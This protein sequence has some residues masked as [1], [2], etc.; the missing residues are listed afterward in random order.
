MQLH[1]RKFTKAEKTVDHLT[2]VVRNLP[3]I[4]FAIDPDG[5]FTLSEGAELNLLGREPEQVVGQS[6]FDV[7]R[8]KPEIIDNIRLALKGEPREYTH[9]MD[10]LVFN[11]RYQPIFDEDNLVKSVV[12]VIRN[13]TELHMAERA[14]K[15]SEFKNRALLNVIPDLVFRFN[16]VG[17]FLDYRSGLADSVAID[18]SQFIGRN[19]RDVMPLEFAENVICLI[20]ESLRSGALQT[21]EYSLP[22][23][24]DSDNVRSF[25]A[26]MVAS[27]DDEVVAF[28]RDVTEAKLIQQTLM[29]HQSQIARLDALKQTS[30]ALAHHVRNAVT[31]IGVTAQMYNIDKPESGARFKDIA[32]S[33]CLRIEAVVNAL[34]EIAQTGDIPVT[35]YLNEQM[36]DL[37]SLIEKHVEMLS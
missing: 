32:V 17:V 4:V 25:E 11:V 14:L 12:G 30:I 36:L 37:D 19:I 35:D 22:I 34:L 1:S 16:S 20:Q 24:I 29:D 8:D 10:G 18:P 28:M 26:R 5:V 33:Q 6:I 31:P 15:E 7:Y 3:V 2:T 13:V 9:S 21:F 27:A 23:P